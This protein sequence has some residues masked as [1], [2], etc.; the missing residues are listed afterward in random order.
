MLRWIS[1]SMG[2]IPLQG[3]SWR[4]NAFPPQSSL[5]IYCVTPVTKSDIAMDIHRKMAQMDNRHQRP[6]V[7]YPVA[8]DGGW[9]TIAWKISVY[10]DGSSDIFMN[11]KLFLKPW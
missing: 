1:W 7:K 3:V 10:D 5:H 2:S 4:V 6:D 9:I 11:G 8:V